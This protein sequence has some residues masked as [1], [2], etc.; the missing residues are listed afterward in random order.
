MLHGVVAFV[1]CEPAGTLTHEPRL[2]ATL[3]AWQA[4]VQVLLQQILSTQ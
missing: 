1:S 4:V 2:P 3:Q